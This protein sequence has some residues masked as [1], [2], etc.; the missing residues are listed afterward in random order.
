MKFSLQLIAYLSSEF[1]IGTYKYSNWK[2]FLYFKFL[3][4]N[5][6]TTKNESDETLLF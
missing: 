4:L 5:S 3:Y 6:G 1:P 2:L